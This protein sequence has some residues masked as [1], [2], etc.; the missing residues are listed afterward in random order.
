M[1]ERYYVKSVFRYNFKDEKTG[2]LI[3]GVKISCDGRQVV[4]ND[5]EGI[6]PINLTTQNL[7]M[8]DKFT[9]LVPGYFI[10]EL[11]PV[12]TKKGLKLE[13]IDAVSEEVKESDR[14]AS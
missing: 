7:L 14:R 3:S 8:F 4:K 13:L 6:E 5:F 10:L 12:P 9:G 1:K 11:D 2:K